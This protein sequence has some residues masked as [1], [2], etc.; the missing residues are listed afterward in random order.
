MP[1][2]LAWWLGTVL[3]MVL[4]PLRIRSPLTRLAAGVIGRNNDVDN[5]RAKAELDWKTQVTYDQAMN[6]IESWVKENL[7]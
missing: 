5:S 3:E 4:T 1:F 7:L 6:R 2:R